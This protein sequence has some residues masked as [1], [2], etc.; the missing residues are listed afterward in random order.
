[1]IGGFRRAIDL[2]LYVHT[3]CDDSSGR[4][5]QHPVKGSFIVEEYMVCEV[6]QFNTVQCIEMSY[7]YNVCIG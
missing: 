6:I 3:E 2:P 4:R 5:C 7:N 1:M